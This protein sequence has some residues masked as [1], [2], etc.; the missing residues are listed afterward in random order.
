[1]TTAGKSAVIA[2]VTATDD[3]SLN[4]TT[5]L[6]LLQQEAARR[7]N[8]L[9]VTIV[10]TFLEA[11]NSKNNGFDY[12]FAIDG[13]AGVPTAFVFGVLDGTH[14]AVAG[15]Y[16]LPKIDWDRVTRA[17]VREDDSEPIAH[18]GNVYNLTPAPGHPLSRYV[19]VTKVEELR[20]LAVSTRVLQEIEG[21]VYEETKKLYTRDSVESGVLLNAYQTFAR[22]VALVADLQAPCSLSAPATFAG[23]IGY[24]G[25]V[26]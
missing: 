22:K 26:R 16:P 6:L 18:A 5:S 13:T 25:Y 14:E 8:V 4:C 17:L 10:P 7:G 15:V 24:R 12:L 3:I 2:I 9:S 23:C 11:L 1:M 21:D 20:V 19:P